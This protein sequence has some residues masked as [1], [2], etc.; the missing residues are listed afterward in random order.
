GGV[1]CLWL[2]CV[3]AALDL[4]SFPTRRSSDLI[5]C[6]LRC[7]PA[8]RFVLLSLI[9]RRL[10]VGSFLTESVTSLRPLEGFFTLI[11]FS[12]ISLS[13]SDRKSTRLNSSHVSIS[14]AVFCLNKHITK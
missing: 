11:G 6:Y 13:T 8:L 9:V 4:R 7:L 1:W 2:R 10:F 3:V 5:S 14:Y 12:A